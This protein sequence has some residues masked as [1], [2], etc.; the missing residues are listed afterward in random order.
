MVHLVLHVLVP[1]VTAR[2]LD[3]TRWR[4]AALLMLGTMLVDVDHLLAEPIYDAQRCSI[5]FHPL[6]GMGPIAVYVVIACVAGSG[7][8]MSVTRGS[9]AGSAWRVPFFLA[10]GLLI[11]M[12]LDGVDCVF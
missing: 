2:A 8:R 10:A 12:A 7:Y 6:H 1:V 4:S 3:P 5:G 9:E 11:H